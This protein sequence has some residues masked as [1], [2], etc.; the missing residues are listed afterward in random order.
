MYKRRE[1]RK[2]FI[3]HIL[4]FFWYLHRLVYILA[5]NL[6]DYVHL[7]INVVKKS[8]SMPFCFTVLFPVAVCSANKT[9]NILYQPAN[10]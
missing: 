2:K 5:T 9:L 7:Y 8:P 10:I 6:L 1:S 4:A 3:A